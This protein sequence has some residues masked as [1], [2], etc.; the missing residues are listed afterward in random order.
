MKT[1]ADFKRR[2]QVGVKLHA[3]YHQEFAGRNENGNGEPVWKDK[4]LGVREVSI[5][6][7]NSFALK[8]WQEG[9]QKFED[10]WCNYPKASEC[11]IIDENTIQILNEDFRVREGVKPLIPILTYK[12]VD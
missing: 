3:T 11:K 8:T 6:Q 1:V 5:K 4:D 10:S 2:L 9:K 7:S 12:F